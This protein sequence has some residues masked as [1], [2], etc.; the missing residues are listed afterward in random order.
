MVTRI[1]GMTSMTSVASTACPGR[2]LGRRA[3]VAALLGL[4][5]LCAGCGQKGP[6]VLPPAAGTATATAATGAASAASGA[7]AP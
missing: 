4:G 5:L 6:L 3:A 7:A 2:P 1:L